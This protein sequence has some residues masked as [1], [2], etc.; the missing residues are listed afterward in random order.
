[1]KTVQFFS[2]KYL[3]DCKKMT[4]T[5]IVEFLDDFR[6]VHGNPN[7]TK[8]K[9]IS[10]KVPEGLLKLFRNK[11]KSEGSPYQTKIKDLMYKD[12]FG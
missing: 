6:L 2:D 9:L 12:L 10:I 7:N 8:S 4:A 3:D 1:M 11:A 5:Q